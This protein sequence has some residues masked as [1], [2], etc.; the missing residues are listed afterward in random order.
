[1]CGDKSKWNFGKP[2]FVVLAMRRVLLIVSALAVT[3]SSSEARHW[4]WHWHGRHFDVPR[5]AYGLAPFEDSVQRGRPWRPGVNPA[6]MVPPKWQL[7]PPDPNWRGKRFLSPDGSS[8]LAVYSFPAANESIASH[9]QSVAFAEGESL[10]NLR[11]ERNW[12]AVSGSK[13][14]RIFYRKAIIACGG[15]VWHQIAFEYPI[16]LQREVEPFVMRAAVIIN[17]AENDGCV[18][19]TSSVNP[20]R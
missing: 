20:D 14:D 16:G 8:W 7:Q 2:N 15:K 13:G 11:G 18:D 19:A 10:T 3:V 5:Y 4:R 12:I 17:Q 9:M 6:D 1:M